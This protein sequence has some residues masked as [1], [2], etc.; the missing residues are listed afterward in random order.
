MGNEPAYMPIQG[1]EH[2]KDILELKLDDYNESN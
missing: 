1:M 2:L